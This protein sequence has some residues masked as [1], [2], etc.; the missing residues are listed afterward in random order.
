M[1]CCLCVIPLC[2]N[3]RQC[4][5]RLNS[6]FKKEELHWTESNDSLWFL[7]QKKLWQLDTFMQSS[8]YATRTS[9]KWWFVLWA[10]GECNIGEGNGNP[11]QCSCLE[12]P[13]DGGAWWAAVSGV[14]QSQ[15]QLK[16]L[17][18]SSSSSSRR[19]QGAGKALLSVA[20]GDTKALLV[21]PNFGSTGFCCSIPTWVYPLVIM[22]LSPACT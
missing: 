2:T 14:A 8:G 20:V 10:L 15:T 13:R 19:M 11:L 5:S 7:N 18:S 4:P 9:E 6:L 22:Y 3:F 17:S 21:S 1:H 12:N 16:Q